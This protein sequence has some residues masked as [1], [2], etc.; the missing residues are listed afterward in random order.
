MRIISGVHKGRIICPPKKFNAR[1]TTDFAKEA[2]FNI[3]AVNFDIE[4]LSVL[5]LFSG[6]GA[7]SYEFASRGCN[8]VDCV[9]N[10]LV[11]YMFIKQVLKKFSLLQIRPMQVDVFSFLS[12][13]SKKY[14]IIFA[15]P[16][17]DMEYIEKIQELSFSLELL[18]IGG[19]LIIEHS[20]RLSFSTLPYFKEQRKY[21]NVNFSFFEKI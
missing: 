10:N 17:Y 16:P 6:T 20:R 3:I 21:G 9:E 18:N 2:L 5:D 15:D 19:W 13:C 7:I 14:D 1:P 4:T 11:H 12:T 8:D